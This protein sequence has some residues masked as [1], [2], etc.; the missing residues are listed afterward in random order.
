MV[1]DVVDVVASQGGRSLLLTTMHVSRLH[2]LDSLSLP[3]A[4]GHPS[5]LTELTAVMSRAG[6]AHACMHVCM[7]T[8]DHVKTRIRGN[9]KPVSHGGVGVD[10]MVQRRAVCSTCK[11]GVVCACGVDGGV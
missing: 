6:P 10:V 11:G 1:G 7:V 2:G 5:R 4:D 8:T 9:S 3:A